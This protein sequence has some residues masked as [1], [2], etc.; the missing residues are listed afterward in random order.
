[1]LMSIDETLSQTSLKQ[2][3]DDLLLTLQMAQ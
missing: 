3:K 2:V 1:M